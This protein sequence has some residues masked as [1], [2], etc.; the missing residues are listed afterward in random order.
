MLAQV[1]EFNPDI[2]HISGLQ[3]AGFYAVLAARLGGCKNVIT[4]VRGS[5]T[6]AIEF[7]AVFK[8][9][10]SFIIEPVTMILSRKIYTVCNYLSDKFRIYKRKNYA[11]VIHNPAPIIDFEKL[12]YCEFR[13]RNKISKDKTVVSVVGRMIYDKGISFVIDAIKNINST[14]I[15]FVFVGDGPYCEIIENELKNEISNKTVFVLGKRNDVLNILAG[16]DIFL[17]PTLHENLSNAL[18]E[19]CVLGLA[20]IATSVGGNKEVITNEVN[21]LL[22]PPFDSTSMKNSVLRLHNNKDEIKRFGKKAKTTVE[23]NFSQKKIF[24]KVKHLYDNLLN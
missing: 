1:K 6:E 21:G 19:A 22:I 20:V 9:V 11:G 16:S 4:T 3:S 14:E 13:E 10:Y 15:V 8:I 23:E 7:N 24:E 2:V 12:D 5:A 17:F 18:L